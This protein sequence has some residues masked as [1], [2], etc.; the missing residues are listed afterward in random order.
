MSVGRR[1]SATISRILPCD[2]E[3][4]PVT[5]TGLKYRG[6]K[7]LRRP[8]LP[9][10][11]GIIMVRNWAVIGTALGAALLATA[12]DASSARYHHHISAVPVPATI[13]DTT[14][15]IGQAPDTGHALSGFQGRGRATAISSAGPAIA[16]TPSLA[17]TIS[18]AAIAITLTSTTIVWVLA[19]VAASGGSEPFRIGLISH[20]SKSAS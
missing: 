13:P 14:S 15:D 2:R 4:D 19:G 11:E 7:L 17:K 10:G 18:M 1:F 8:R 6:Y 9:S 20:P 3:K 5:I 16:A 12:A